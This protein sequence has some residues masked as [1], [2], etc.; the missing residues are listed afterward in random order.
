MERK[1]EREKLRRVRAL[2]SVIRERE[3]RRGGGRRPNEE[4]RPVFFCEVPQQ[5]VGIRNS[6]LPLLLLCECVC[7]SC[8]LHTVA[9]NNADDAVGVCECLACL[10]AWVG[11]GEGEY[12]ESAWVSNALLPVQQQERG[13]HQAKWR[14]RQA[15]AEQKGGDVKILGA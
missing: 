10:L 4:R 7:V 12:R 8:L 15:Q 13:R 11:E 1:E 2:A 5:R 6:C 14:R 9:S 3:P